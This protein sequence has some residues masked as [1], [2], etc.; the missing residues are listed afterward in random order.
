MGNPQSAYLVTVTGQVVVYVMITSVVVYS[1]P[2]G[3]GTVTTP[4]PHPP[5]QLVTVSVD[6][7]KSVMILVVPC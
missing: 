2:V 6:V 5:T 4:P 3:P 1:L 7:V